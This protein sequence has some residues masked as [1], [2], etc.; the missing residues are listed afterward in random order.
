MGHLNEAVAQLGALAEPTRL[1]IYRKLVR[2]APD[3]LCVGDLLP[4]A[5]LS[6]PTLS[7]HLKTLATAQLVPRRKQGRNVYYAPNFAAMH[8]LMEFLM[9]N[10]CEG[11][12]CLDQLRA[13]TCCPTIERRI[14]A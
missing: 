8:A 7:F 5:G 4:D 10:C 2:H 14:E 1:G 6:Q 13:L 11:E 12:Q 3:G 9:E